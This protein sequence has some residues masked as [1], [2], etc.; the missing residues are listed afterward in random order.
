MPQYVGHRILV[1]AWWMA[2][3]VTW[4]AVFTVATNSTELSW[5]TQSAFGVAATALGALGAIDVAVH[6]LPRQISYVAFA[7]IS[8]LLL[9]GSPSRSQ[10][11]TDLFVGTLLMFGVIGSLRIVSRGSMGKGDLH[12]APLLGALI[13]WFDPNQVLIACVVMAMSAALVSGALVVSGR[14]EKS[15]FIAYGP[16]MLLGAAVAIVGAGG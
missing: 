8:I 5:A 7:L 12:L 1:H 11:T 2:G 14:R 6:R 10:K 9:A 15:D 13:G 3:S 16:F 4:L